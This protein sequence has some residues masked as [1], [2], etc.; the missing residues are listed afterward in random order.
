MITRN[1][2]LDLLREDQAHQKEWIKHGIRILESPDCR[3]LH[4]H[5]GL[6]LVRDELATLQVRKQ[7]TDRT[8]IPTWG[9]I[10]AIKEFEQLGRDDRILSFG[11]V[12]KTLAALIYILIRTDKIKLL[13]CISVKKDKN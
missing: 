10:E 4:P 2:L 5:P 9:L 11:V 6:N 7:T 8:N 1:L 13:G 3:F 12:T